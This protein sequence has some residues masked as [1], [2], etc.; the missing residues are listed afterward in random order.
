MKNKV[1]HTNKRLADAV[2]KL[3]V[4]RRKDESL[5]DLRRELHRAQTELHGSVRYQNQLLKEANTLRYRYDV[6]YNKAGDGGCVNSSV[7]SVCAYIYVITLGDDTLMCMCV[8]VVFVEEV[9]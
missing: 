8:L 1:K 2:A 9:I 3:A 5:C 6:F 4:H 7:T